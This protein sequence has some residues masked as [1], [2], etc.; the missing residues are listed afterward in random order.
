MAGRPPDEAVRGFGFR[1]HGGTDRLEFVEIP[2][3]V[4]G[5][6]EIQV[7]VAAAAFNRLDRFV[8]AGIPGV[9]I[10]LP[11]VLGS[12]AA[13]WVSALGEGVTGPP[14]GSRVLVNPGLSDGTCDACRAGQENACRRFQ[15]L[16]EHVQGSMTESIVVPARNVYA[17]PD[18]MEFTDAA[19]APL[20]FQ[21]VW[22]ALRTVGELRTGESVAVIG[23]GGG[24]ATTAL[25]V[26]KLLG[27]RVA[28]VSRSPKKLE[29]ARALGADATLLIDEAN[30]VDKLLWAWSGKQGV[31]VVFDSVGAPTI[32]RSLRAI[33]RGGRVVVIGATGGA[34]VELDLR[35]LFWRQASIRGS[36]MSTRAEFEEMLVPLRRGELRATVDSVFDLS[37]APA[38][39]DRLVSPDLFGKV[40]VRMP[41][42][43]APER[44]ET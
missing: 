40:V 5:P 6:G 26:A 32:E 30:P 3:P 36:T 17:I 28:V 27:A 15:I 16:G 23:A 33:A 29:R 38:A 43:P 14:V 34:N 7:R 35:T 44:S 39:F 22:R 10:A 42:A 2:V 24:V 19:A 31:D 4:A 12:D 1:E 18:S 8:L 21:T 11:H 25:Q 20:V 9:P 41:P 37:E 13:G